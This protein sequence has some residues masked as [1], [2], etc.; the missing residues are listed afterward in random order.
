MQ[1]ILTA[2]ATNKLWKSIRK[3]SLSQYGFTPL[4]QNGLYICV[5]LFNAAFSNDS[6]VLRRFLGSY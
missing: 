6:V 4:S 5:L 3:W 1:L 2:P